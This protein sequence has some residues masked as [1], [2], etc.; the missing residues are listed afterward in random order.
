[1][2]EQVIPTCDATEA[3]LHGR[4]GRMPFLREMSQMIGSQG[5]DHVARTHKHRK[6]ERAERG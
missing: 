2:G 4:S 5:V 3:T 1:M 6:E